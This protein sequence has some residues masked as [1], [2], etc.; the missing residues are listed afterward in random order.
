MAYKYLLFDHDGVLVDTEQWYYQATRRAL[1]ELDIALDE[2]TYQDIMIRGV[3]AWE[4]AEEA[5]VEP[6]LLTA[7]KRKRNIWYQEYLR[8]EDLDIPGVIETLRALSARHPMAIVTTCKARDFD[9]IQR[10]REIVPLMDFVLKREDYGLSKPHPEPYLRALE[11]FGARPEEALVIEDS[12]RGLRAA[13]AAGI[14]CCIVHN[15]F[16][17]RHDFS[18]ARYRLPTLAGLHDIL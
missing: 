4:L 3:A 17:A 13:V 9:L 6:V 5:G 10:D 12:E 14:D 7:Q 18:A 8:S 11:R 16:T 2:Q 1:A 15:A